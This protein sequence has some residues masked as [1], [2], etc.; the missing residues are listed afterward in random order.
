MSS[1]YPFSS[2]DPTLTEQRRIYWARQLKKIYRQYSKDTHALVTLNPD[3]NAFIQG[4][5]H[6][7]AK[8]NLAG[9]VLAKDMIEEAYKGGI[10]R[11]TVISDSILSAEGAAAGITSGAYPGSLG[12]ADLKS[13]ELLQIRT[14]ENIQG[15]TS[16]MAKKAKEVMTRGVLEGKGAMP[17]ARD[18]RK[19]M[20]NELWKAS[21][22]VRTEYI[23]ATNQ[24]AGNR[25]ID[26]GFTHYSISVEDADPECDICPPEREKVYK[27]GHGPV[28]PLHQNCRCSIYPVK[29]PDVKVPF[30]R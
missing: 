7:S 28:P 17:M 15:M 2:R 20:N 25:Y 4:I 14:Y 6:F 11:A 24:S 26:Y 10:Y 30:N 22:I 27:F 29:H 8:T 18:M 13:V 5:D 21:R 9:Q 1:K 12:P 3:I 23:N 16:E 19:V